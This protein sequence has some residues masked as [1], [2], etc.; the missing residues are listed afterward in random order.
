[1]KSLVSVVLPVR[2]SDL[3]IEKTLESI[4]NQTYTNIELIVV[5]DLSE[6]S[7][8]SKVEGATKKVLFDVVILRNAHNEGVAKS[9]NKALSVAKGK[10]IAFIDGDDIWLPNKIEKQVSEMESKQLDISFTNYMT[11]NEKYCVNSKRVLPAREYHLSDFMGSNPAGLLTVMIRNNGGI[12]ELFPSI[13][14]EDYAAW[15]K[16]MKAG[17]KAELLDQVT[18]KYMIHDSMSSNKFKSIIWTIN[19]LKKYGELNFLQLIVATYRYGVNVISRKK[20]VTI[21]PD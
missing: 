15:I 2:N 17:A 11:M 18:A 10:Y 13:A 19:I 3:T 6:D 5:D 1:M 4:K 9:R 12:A 14:H 21:L 16:M 20:A 8:L 7:T